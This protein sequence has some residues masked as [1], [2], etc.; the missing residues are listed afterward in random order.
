MSAAKKQAAA[1]DTA[2]AAITLIEAITQALAYEMR[3]DESV[4]ELGEDVGVKGGVFRA[5]AGLSQTSGTERVLATP[6]AE[7]TIAGLT[8]GMASQGMKQIGRAQV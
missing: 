4:V 2:P 6:L 7:T 3:N 8:D 5:T 1:A